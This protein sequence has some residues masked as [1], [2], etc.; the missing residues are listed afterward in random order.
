MTS[1]VNSVFYFMHI[2]IMYSYLPELDDDNEKITVYNGTFLA[3]R[4]LVMIPILPTVLGIGAIIYG[5]SGFVEDEEGNRTSTTI[6]FDVAL[7][8][9]SQ[10]ISLV[11][12]GIG[13]FKTFWNGLKYRP[14]TNKR[15][16]DKDS[17]LATAVRIYRDYP[18]LFWS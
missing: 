11:L 5:S 15:N 9:I 13:F 10:A 16:D 2:T 8:R 3:I 12:A 18:A 17:P 1:I 6:D 7:A 4:A 14:A